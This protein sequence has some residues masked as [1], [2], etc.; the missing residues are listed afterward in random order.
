MNILKEEISMKTNVKKSNAKAYV[1]PIILMIIMWVI[2]FLPAVTIEFWQA[3]LLWIGFSL[4]TVFI[5]AYFT[6]KSPEF[7]ARRSKTKETVKTPAFLKLYFI[8]FILPGI[9]F[10]FAW[11]KEPVWLIILS[12]LIF[13]AAY[14]FIF[15]VFRENTYASTVI[16]VENKQ[17]VITTGPYSIVRHPMYT[18]MLIMSLFMPLALG[19]YFSLIP[20]LFIIPIIVFRIKGEEKTLLKELDGYSR[21]CKKTPYKLIP[22]IW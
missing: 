20:M 5:A 16:Q 1:F 13:F 8:G 12:N 9:D 11:S 19:S 21:Y 4:I 2:L 3:W 6:K 18:G 15:F 14:I 17:K 10:H 22:L 7:L